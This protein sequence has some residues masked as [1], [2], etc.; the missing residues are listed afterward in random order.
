MA[1][2]ASISLV[3][4]RLFRAL[5]EAADSAKD[6]EKTKDKQLV[7]LQQQIH[8][9]VQPVTYPIDLLLTGK[10]GKLSDDQAKALKSTQ[11]ALQNVLILV[12]SEPSKKTGTSSSKK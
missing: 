7:A 10:M 9:L 11:A 4:A 12:A 3:N 1:D 8:E 5:Q 2:Y 6:R